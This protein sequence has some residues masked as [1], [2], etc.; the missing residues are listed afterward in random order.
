[1]TTM[2]TPPT[3]HSPPGQ[4]TLMPLDPAG[5][6]LVA[7]R[8]P[9]IR[10]NLLPEEITAGRNARRIRDVLIVAV[11]LVIAALGGWY[12]LAAVDRNEAADNLD[13][14][15]QQVDKTRAETKR[16]EYTKVTQVIEEQ[17]TIKNEL[18][19]TMANDLPWSTVLGKVRN[20][21]VNGITVTSANGSLLDKNTAASAANAGAGAKQTVATL[22]ILGNGKDKK[23]IAAYLDALAKIDGVA[24]VYLTTAGSQDDANSGSKAKGWTFSITANLTSELLCSRFTTTHCTNGGK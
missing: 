6:P 1:M 4:T 14:M 11:V 24:H 13:A 19:V 5:A 21:G 15:T 2:Q 17:E 3:T 23:T 18:N 20:S 10:A 8:V 7:L 9:A 22:T 12:Y 16:Q